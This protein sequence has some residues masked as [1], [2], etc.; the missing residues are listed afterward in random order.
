[1]QAWETYYYGKPRSAIENI[2]EKYNRV[3]RYN[4]P[5]IVA[6]LGLYGDNKYSKGWVENL[7]QKIEY[8]PLVKAVVY[9]NDKEPHV[10]PQPYGAPDWRV[11]APLLFAAL[12]ET[13]VVTSP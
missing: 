11:Y 2:W 1:M 12:R 5:I 8:L 6:E 13:S 7:Q 3:S 10:W 9:F 4:K